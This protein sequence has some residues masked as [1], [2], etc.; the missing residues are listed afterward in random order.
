MGFVHGKL[1]VL[2]FGGVDASGWMNEAK[3]SGEIAMNDVTTA[4]DGKTDWKTFQTGLRSAAGSVAGFLESVEDGS[5]ELLRET[6]DSNTGFPLSYAPANWDHGLPVKMMHATETKYDI[7][8]PVSE[9]E[10]VSA[11]F[12]SNKGRLDH[13]K[14][15][16]SLAAKT[17]TGSGSNLDN[18]ASST[19]GGVAHLH[20]VGITGTGATVTG[21]IKH[22]PD[23]SSWADLVTFTAKTDKGGERVEIPA[24]TTIQRYTKA[25][26]T[27]AGTNPSINIGI[28]LARR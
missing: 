16:T 27:I 1:Q 10:A 13:G 20:V 11:E 7:S 5:D 23:G 17:A 2:L 19:A 28:A 6:L 24:G 21:K 22:S 18:E 14:A 8:A 4:K 15:L 26:W 25:D 9:V 12:A 3:V